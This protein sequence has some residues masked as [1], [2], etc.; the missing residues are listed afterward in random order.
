MAKSDN[1]KKLLVEG[2]DDLRVISCYARCNG[3]GIYNLVQEFVRF[4]D[5]I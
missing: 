3:T 2:K 1:S 5:D 4:I